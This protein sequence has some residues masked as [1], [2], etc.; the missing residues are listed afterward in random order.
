MREV[1]LLVEHVHRGLL[2]EGAALGHDV[3]DVALEPEV[4]LAVL[5][6]FYGF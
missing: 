2:V 6:L 1:Y 5:E 3:V 4:D